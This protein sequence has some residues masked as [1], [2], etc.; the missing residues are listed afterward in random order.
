MVDNRKSDGKKDEKSK[1]NAED[2]NQNKRKDDE[3]K[4]IPYFENGQKSLRIPYF[5]PNLPRVKRPLQ[6]KYLDGQCK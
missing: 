3:K 4:L 5:A 6:P 1:T 2:N